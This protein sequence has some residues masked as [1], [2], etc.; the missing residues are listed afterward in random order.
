MNTH[1]NLG[2]EHERKLAE[3]LKSL[4]LEF[5][6]HNIKTP[7]P[8]R[9]RLALP[10]GLS[11]LA[12]AIIGVILYQPI[13]VRHME[14]TVAALPNPAGT[15]A[16]TFSVSRE[17]DVDQGG[18]KA[19]R[20]ATRKPVPTA[21]EI[22]GSGVVVAPRMTTVFSKYEGRITHIAVEAGDRVEAGQI[23]VTLEDAGARFAL[24]QAEAARAAAQLVLASRTIDLSQ[25]RASL[26]R[27]EI[28]ALKD[29]TSHQ[30]L[31]ET[32]TAAIRASNA[33]A[34]AKQDLARTGLTIRIAEEAIAELTVHAPFAGTVTRLGAQVGDTVLARADS[35][36]E[37]QSLL[38]ITD[39]TVLVIDAD[40][41]E[42]NIAS[43]KPGLHGEAVL[44]GFP[45]QPFAFTVLRLAPVASTEKGTITLRLSLT[46]P[47][48][49]IRPNMAARIR[50]PLISQG[51]T[52]R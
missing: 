33:V 50:I 7:K 23:L 28:L 20:P 47:P 18:R 38:T 14:T 10:A 49:G 37:S 48:A 36:R 24:Y 8:M 29:A 30:T 42:T 5:V 11:A 2:T 43:L 4:S 34:Q 45:G 25:A 13:V 41:A 35:V 26:D 52:T 22:T 51:D 15:T 12:A 17:A 6:S 39:T 44:D 21:S 1:L 46:N 3:T 19:E 16:D 9:R 40:V 32:R 31:E 27:T